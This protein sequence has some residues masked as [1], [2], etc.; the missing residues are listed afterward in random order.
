MR[1]QFTYPDLDTGSSWI[2]ATVVLGVLLTSNGCI[3]RGILA[4]IAGRLI[5]GSNSSPIDVLNVSKASD[6]CCFLG[7]NSVPSLSFDSLFSSDSNSSEP[8]VSVCCLN[9]LWG[10]VSRSVV[11]LSARR[12]LPLFSEKKVVALGH[13]EIQPS[14]GCYTTPHS[15]LQDHETTL[16]SCTKKHH[17]NSKTRMNSS[18]MR[19]ARSL[20]ISRHIP[21]T[22]PRTPHTPRQP[23]SPVNRMTDRHG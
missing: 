12:F 22:P 13:W 23:R 20:T 21:R 2:S 9:G 17:R 8:Q 1:R 6:R 15:H 11:V 4:L 10:G 7:F 14:N 3:M 5:M 19:T 16:I 18:R